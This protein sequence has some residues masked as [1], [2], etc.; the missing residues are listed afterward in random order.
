MLTSFC[1]FFLIG[2]ILNNK[3]VLQYKLL[4]LPTVDSVC[5]WIKQQNR[6]V[7]SLESVV[8]MFKFQWDV[9]RHL[10]DASPW[11]PSRSY[12]GERG[13]ERLR[14][15]VTGDTLYW[16]PW[17]TYIHVGI[18]ASRIRDLWD[19]GRTC[20]EKLKKNPSQPHQKKTKPRKKLAPDWL[21]KFSK[22]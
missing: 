11:T 3:H 14:G 21:M 16:A 19:L 18:P 20:Q 15:A 10:F 7:I 13:A 17:F 12:K 1:C 4:S 22:F 5:A 8:Q 2:Y 6:T 9:Y